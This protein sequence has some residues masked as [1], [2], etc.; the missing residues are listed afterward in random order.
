VS[1]VLFLG[2]LAATGFGTVTMD[3]GRALI[4]RGV[5][6]RFMSLN[7]TGDD[8]PEPF[9]S[10]TALLD[11]PSGWLAMESKEAVGERLGELTRRLSGMFTGALFDD[12]WTPESAIILGDV[13]SL[14]VSPVLDFIPDGF[15]A[16]HYVPVEGIGLPPAWALVWQ[17]ARPVAMTEFGADQIATVMGERPP[18][19]YHGVDSH[20]FAPVSAASPI[21]II[22]GPRNASTGRFQRRTDV[23]VLR[24]KAECRRFLGWPQDAFILFRSD[25]HMPRKAYDSLFRA[26][27]PV[28]A[29]NPHAALIYHCLPIDQGGDLYDETSKYGPIV[30]WRPCPRHDKHPVFGGVASRL[31]NTGLSCLAGGVPREI[32]RAMYCAADLYVST[33][34]EG[35]G[36]TIAES[37]ACGTPAVG[38]RYSSVPE[39]IGE[40]GV[41]VPVGMLLPNIYSHFWAIPNEE[42]F[43]R[44]VARLIGDD[45][46]RTRMGKLGPFHVARQFTWKRAAEQFDELIT[47]SLRSEV[48]A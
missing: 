15:P 10:R 31:V 11:T 44:E 23:H 13:G 4:A 34:A 26:L 42:E 2:D 27:A 14:K 33:S 35:F 7:E 22:T 25:R 45:V 29:A 32:L 38:L 39:V 1:R 36:L 18:V 47:A 6:V 16:F 20:A 21:R 17:K 40:A 28:L 37:L 8:L 30:G 41:T 5:D 3:L 48:A 46:T 19:V 43:G 24:S 9:K 12:G